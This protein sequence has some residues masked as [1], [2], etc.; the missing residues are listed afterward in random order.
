LYQSFLTLKDKLTEAPILIAP[1]C[2]QSFELMCDVSD[3][4]VGAV[5]G[6]RI[7]KHF[8]PIH[9]ASKI[10]NQ[11][12]AN[13]TTTEKEMLAEAKR[14]YKKRSF[15]TFFHGSDVRTSSWE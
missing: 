15:P 3:Y 8:W 12:E 14:S 6:Q 4:T 1:N 10:M 9:Y 11:A 7:E 5:L 2:D 13:Y